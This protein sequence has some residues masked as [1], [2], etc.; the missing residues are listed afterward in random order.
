MLPP[1]IYRMADGKW[2]IVSNNGLLLVIA[3]TQE[4]A[5]LALS[6]EL[7]KWILSRKSTH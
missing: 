2:A 5:V 4:D 3:N 6:E 1:L 7:D